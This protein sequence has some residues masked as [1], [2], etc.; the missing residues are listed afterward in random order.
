MKKKSGH[1]GK[2]I[3][4]FEAFAG[5]LSVVLAA[6]TSEWPTVRCWTEPHLK[7]VF[8]SVRN[9]LAR[10]GVLDN[11]RLTH[12]SLLDWLCQI[13][14]CRKIETEGRVFH[15]LE[16]GTKSRIEID[17]FELLMADRPAGVICY[18][19]ALSFHSLTTQVV[20]QYHIA[21]LVPPSAASD[22]KIQHDSALALEPAARSR[23][24][25]PYRLGK[26]LF[27]YQDTSYYVTRRSARLL[28]GI[29]VRSRGPRTQIRITTFEQ[30]LLDALYKPLSCGGPS[31]VLAAWQ[32]A[33]SLRKMDEE[34]LATYLS[35]MNYPATA[36]RLG[37]VFDL[38]GYSP[39]AELASVLD[40]FRKRI[41]RNAP[42]ARISLLPGIPYQNLNERWL[43]TTP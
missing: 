5:H 32:E 14:L 37:A 20:G 43:V 18:F 40:E 28:P 33:L 42:F 30:T 24:S 12:Q 8:K 38:I 11:R 15:L 36:R 35:S 19:S 3:A 2:A 23:S 9:D 29:Q 6:P 39:G 17:P 4:Y 25:E 26:L 13:G 16:F 21:E 34:R 22:E 27:R 10:E 31:V 7:Q 41:D 1:F